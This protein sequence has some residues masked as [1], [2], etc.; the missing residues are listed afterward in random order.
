MESF[1]IRLRSGRS[2]ADRPS[3]REGWGRG[4]DCVMGQV[5]G[6]AFS[7]RRCVLWPTIFRRS[8]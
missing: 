6:L 7:T 3:L 2:D 1:D 8:I 4:E 5:A